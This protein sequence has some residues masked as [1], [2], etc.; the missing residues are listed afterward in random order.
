[1]KFTTTTRFAHK[2]FRVKRYPPTSTL[3][4]LQTAKLKKQV[5]S[6]DIKSRVRRRLT[7]VY[8]C[9]LYASYCD[10]LRSVVVIGEISSAVSR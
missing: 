1:M 6:L 5:D 4:R 8:R 3:R 2:D 7:D 9:Q 10:Q